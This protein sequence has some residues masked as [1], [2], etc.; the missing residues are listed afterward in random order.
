MLACTM[1]IMTFLPYPGPGCGSL[2]RSPMN[3]TGT[4]PVTT[5]GSAPSSS[6]SLVSSSLPSTIALRRP[7]PNT[8]GELGALRASS[9]RTKSKF[10][11]SN[12]ASKDPLDI[13][14]IWS[15][16]AVN[17]GDSALL[18]AANLGGICECRLAPPLSSSDWPCCLVDWTDHAR[19]IL[20]FLLS[21][22][23]SSPTMPA[24]SLPTHLTRLPETLAKSRRTFG[25]QQRIFVAVP[26]SF[27]G[28]AT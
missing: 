7:K 9:R 3:S 28:C 20:H 2:T 12:A 1:S 27:S 18:N 23:P 19:D 24:D 22:L 13:A 15:F 16:E 14:E 4:F 5:V 11:T 17:H 26:H 10:S 25:Y 8:S 6:S 21:Y